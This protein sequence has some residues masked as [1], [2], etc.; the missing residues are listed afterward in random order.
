MS[1]WTIRTVVVMVWLGGIF[2]G[3]KV[4]KDA[5]YQKLYS[6]NP[7]AADPACGT[8]ADD[9]AMACV[10]AYQLGGRNFCATGCNR[11]TAP[12]EGD[13]E[14]ICLAAGD[15]K[16]EV[17]GAK[18]KKCQPDTVG[19]ACGQDELSCLRTDLIKN[20]GVCMNVTPCQTSADCRDPVRAQCFGELLRNNYGPQAGL[21]S[22]HTYCVQLGCRATGA[23]C[24]P[25]E[26]CLRNRLGPES[27][28]PDI[29]VPNCDSNR[30]CP[31]N[32][33]CYPDL[34]SKSSP[35]ICLP[36]LLG[37]R[38]RTRMDCL[39]GDCVDTGAG[40]NVC[41]VPCADNDDCAKFDSEHG[42]FFCNDKK[43][44]A[45][46]RAFRGSTCRT[47]G[48]CRT[49]EICSIPFFAPATQTTGQCLFACGD[50]RTCPAY[51]GVAHTC[52]SQR[53]TAEPPICWPGHIGIPCQT[54][55]NCA[56]GL[57]CRPTGPPPRPS[58]C[59][60]ICLTDEDCVANR[61]TR[62][63]LNRDGWCAA[64]LNLC[65]APQKEGKACDRANQCESRQC[66]NNLC[67]P[68]PP[69]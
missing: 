58:I 38:C 40:F 29:C 59:S 24:S 36:G 28:P 64:G 9:K 61:A 27:S 68:L 62:D 47:T 30:N 11:K 12:P 5:F 67:Q 63:F 45:G 18:L 33:F 3:C 54:D 8:D 57:K 1:E 60:A 26:T 51:G 43:V 10:A 25:G 13:T 55:D 23:A 66:V 46:V 48:D 39:V 15:P 34:Y 41:T 56:W 32:Y 16:N 20:E 14:G 4:D 53:D 37:L 21:K 50:N 22:D 6:C 31:P 2:S 42:T 69:F 17:S 65:Q 35:A 19:N 49:G 44:C 7:N 52:L